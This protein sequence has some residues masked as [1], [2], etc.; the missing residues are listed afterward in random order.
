MD[1]LNAEIYY[2]YYLYLNDG[3]GKPAPRP[4]IVSAP[5]ALKGG[6]L[7]SMTVG[8]NDQIWFINLIR[9]SPVKIKV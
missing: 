4:T 8:S 2:P 7:F 9:M 1:E 3:S 6:Q 5:S